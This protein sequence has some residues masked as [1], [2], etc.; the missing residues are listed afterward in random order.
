MHLAAHGYLAEHLVACG[1]ATH[2][3]QWMQ[4][5]ADV[6]GLPMLLTQVQDAV[7]LGA[8]IMAATAGGAYPS[9]VEAAAAMVH[10]SRQFEPDAERH[11]AYAPFVKAHIGTYPRLRELQHDLAAHL[12]SVPR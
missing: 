11:E 3:A 7:S 6:T 9:L 5:H 12:G 1:G 10:E 2:S 8:C 4:M